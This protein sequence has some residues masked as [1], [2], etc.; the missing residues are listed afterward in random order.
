MEE[1]AQ[2]TPEHHTQEHHVAEHAA[3]EHHPAPEH[4]PAAHQSKQG[5]P[6]SSYMP[7][8]SAGLSIIAIIV[9]VMALMSIG[10]HAKTPGGNTLTTTTINA[11]NVSGYNI[12]GALITP[13]VSL[14]DAPVI[15]ANQSFGS[16]LTGIN[17]QFN[18]SEL[19][20]IN[21]ASNAYFEIA[22]NMLLNKSLT[23]IVGTSAKTAPSFLVNGKP[24]VMYY[25]S[26]TC[27]YCAENKW[28]MALA[29]S[30]FGSF[31]NLFKGY[32]ALQDG[33]IPTIYWSPAQY[34][35]SSTGLGD[36][37]TSNYVNFFAIEDANPITAGFAPNPTKT[38]ASRINAT[39]NVAYSDAFKFILALN[40]N[41]AYMGTPYTIWGNFQVTGADAV[42]FGNSTP[43]S[44]NDLAMSKWTHEQVL[45][46][47]ANP[48]SQ[49]AWTEY[50]AADLYV[51]M[52]CN[53]INNA[54][55]VC[56]LSAIKSI[57]SGESA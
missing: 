4:H 34:N 29:L 24:A 14:A 22:G 11:V 18:S 39:G 30:R 28:A 6:L 5:A 42:D 12:Q 45:S 27:I 26:I 46:Q 25:G 49:F 35:K 48:E 21:N 41:T 55:P 23:N 44:S 53:S 20:M 52:L 31:S 17:A 57:N 50:A 38:I 15:T 3:A 36:F 56:Q 43:T 7:Y 16:R 9:S 51:A 10:G 19:S 40:N 47:L 2:H 1:S 54:A 33:D 13:N 32:S 8:I 37:Y